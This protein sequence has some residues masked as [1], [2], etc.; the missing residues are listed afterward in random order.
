M[1]QALSFPFQVSDRGTA[2]TAGRAEIIRQQLEQLLFTIPGERVGRPAFGC[3][4]QRLVFAGTTAETIA[5]AEYVIATA[6]RRTMAALIRLD[7]V[8]VSVIETL[9]QVDILYTVLETGEELA[10][11]FEQPLETPP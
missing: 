11:S 4:I 10:Q 2:A 7:A 8:R 6:I 9:M 3:G 5:A 1:A